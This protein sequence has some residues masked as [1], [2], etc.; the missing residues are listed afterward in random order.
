[1]ETHALRSGAAATISVEKDVG[2]PTQTQVFKATVDDN[3]K[4][5]GS[6]QWTKIKTR[7]GTQ[8][9]LP[10]SWT[11]GSLAGRVLKAVSDGYAS[12]LITGTSSSGKTSLVKNL[13]HSIHIRDGA[14]QFEM[15]WLHSEELIEF[16]IFLQSLIPKHNYFV[17]LDDASFVADAQGASKN[18]L[19]KIGMEINRVRH[20]LKGGKIIICVINHA[21]TS[22]QKSV[23]RNVDFTICTSLVSNQQKSIE[24]LFGAR[25]QQKV[26]RFAGYF[27]HQKIGTGPLEISTGGA[28]GQ[29]VVLHSDKCRI[30]LIQEVN[31]VHYF[32]W[33]DESCKICNQDYYADE[34][35]QGVPYTESELV[36]KIME[37]AVRPR[38]KEVHP[39]LV[40]HHGTT[41]KTWTFGRDV[42]SAMMDW[43]AKRA[44]ITK[45]TED[46]YEQSIHKALDIIAQ[47]K[48]IDPAKLGFFL[49]EGGLEG[50]ATK[51]IMGVSRFTGKQEK[52]LAHWEKKFGS[53]EK[54]S[55]WYETEKQR[56]LN[57]HFLKTHT[58]M[59]DAKSVSVETPEIKHENTRSDAM[60]K[61]LKEVTPEQALVQESKEIALK[62]DV[63][64]KTAD[65]KK[66]RKEAPTTITNESIEEKKRK[67]KK[68]AAAK[69][70]YEKNKAKYKQ[71][72]QDN[73]EVY[74]ARARKQ[75][76]A[77][78]DYSKFSF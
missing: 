69:K 30:G 17:V 63:A 38:D 39:S 60:A 29:K 10:Q 43:C 27:R 25:N 46:N 64:E 26:N 20:N 61:I 67:A 62:A 66:T 71:H 36:E 76:D 11:M 12:M 50:I 1:M 21:L 55:E 32:V 72:Y 57:P 5:G 34:E 53:F 70:Y 14:P 16:D 18:T 42:K 44:N 6:Y 52:K 41:D 47:E 58:S 7:D 23:F 3:W 28:T 49:L 73:K 31:W 65:F 78:R 35:N 56:L 9:N 13:M 22:V 15:K 75:T 45:F 2:A 59:I 40:K 74:K 24:D 51:E 8:V 19:A 77:T 54:F 4:A 68:S 33:T 48:G 37:S